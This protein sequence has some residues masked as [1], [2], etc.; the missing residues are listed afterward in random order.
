MRTGP[1]ATTLKLEC[2]Q[3]HGPSKK[4]AIKCNGGVPLGLRPR[5]TTVRREQRVQAAVQQ[6]S[7]GQGG[8]PAHCGRHRPEPPT[9]NRLVQRHAMP[10]RAGSSQ[11]RRR[12]QRRHHPGPA[13]GVSGQCP[14]PPSSGWRCAACDG[15][16]RASNIRTLDPAQHHA[17]L[18]PVQATR[19]PITAFLLRFMSLRQVRWLA[20]T[21]AT[22]ARCEPNLHGANNVT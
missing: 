1:C 19:R 2:A 20:N 18:G 22:W 11:G 14:I 6:S 4:V 3:D 7:R 9:P 16:G 13:L 15:R 5:A 21:Q 10:A 8:G 12:Q 17:G